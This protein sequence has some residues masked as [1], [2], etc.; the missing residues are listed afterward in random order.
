MPYLEPRANFQ[1]FTPGLAH[2]LGRIQAAKATI[3][4]A[5]ILPASADALR[6]AAEVGTIHF[7]NLIE[8]NRLGI[9]EAQRAAR[10][11][12]D[13]R[14]R[15]EIE[16]VNYVDALKEL[17]RRLEG[18]GLAFS[19]QLF[20]D[21]H[22][23]VT[24]GLGKWDEPF[25]PQ[26]EGAWRDGEAVIYDPLSGRIMHAGSAP[27]DVE[28]RMSELIDWVKRKLEDPVGW[29][30]PV[31]AGVLHFN[32]T[33]THPFADGNGRT[34]RLLSLALLMRTGY[35]PHRLFNFD[36]H[37]GLDK[38]AYI[39][40]LR[41]VARN[42][43]NLEE[44]L[45]YFLD[46]IAT[47]YERVVGEI[48]RLSVIGQT[49]DGRVIQLSRG[50]ERALTQ[51]KLANVSEFK[52][53]DYEQAAGV[54]KTQANTD[55]TRLADSGVLLRI[56]DGPGRRYRF[57]TAAPANPWTG[58]GGG[59]PRTWT[60]G[61]ILAELRDLVGDDGT[62]PPLKVFA[63]AGKTPLY[64]AMSRRGGIA[65]WRARFKVVGAADAG[66]ASQTPGG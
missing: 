18:D 51:L 21:V 12:L 53:S 54:G 22:R 6:F 14:T 58:R 5:R 25:K 1:R 3:E 34:A 32:I 50:Q 35:A 43:W 57:P 52:R 33:D 37:Y 65:S 45:T 24:K 38:T 44:W 4:Q 59:R 41:S 15:A 17:D 42:T 19:E 29:P 36:A 8:G 27:E 2:Q 26:H 56:G 66:N 63:A 23:E 46:G 62:V 11:E 49:A 31:I 61:R 60:D 64:Q 39:E 20:L 40:A 30:P 28:A 48:A 47:E 13:R 55:L 9:L 10:G 7:S 16:L